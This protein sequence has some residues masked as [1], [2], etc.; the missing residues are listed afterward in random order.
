MTELLWL[1]IVAAIGCASRQLLALAEKGKLIERW[2][3]K[4]S[5]LKGIAPW[6]R[7]YQTGYTKTGVT[8][9]GCLYSFP[10]PL[11]QKQ[12][13]ALQSIWIALPVCRDPF[14]KNAY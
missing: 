11:D 6:R 3:R 8:H 14:R 4:I 7:D 13:K 12:R 9:A 10:D 2:G 1:G 5:G